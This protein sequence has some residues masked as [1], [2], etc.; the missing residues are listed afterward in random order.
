MSFVGLE[1]I[2]FVSTDLHEDVPDEDVPDGEESVEPWIAQVIKT[3]RVSSLIC[4]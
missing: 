2:P 3:Y 4:E 1:L